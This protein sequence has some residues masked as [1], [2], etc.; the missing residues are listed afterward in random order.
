MQRLVLL[1]LVRAGG[2][3]SLPR[4]HKAVCIVFSTN[5]LEINVENTLRSLIRDGYVR[6]T[7]RQMAVGYDAIGVKF[8]PKTAYRITKDGIRVLVFERKLL[9]RLWENVTIAEEETT[10]GDQVTTQTENGASG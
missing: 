10:Q 9:D 2:R 4:L 7:T 1:L 6:R 8:K 3:A 5:I